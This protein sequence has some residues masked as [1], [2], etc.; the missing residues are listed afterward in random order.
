[1][2]PEA[3]YSL[4]AVTHGPGDVGATPL[5]ILPRMAKGVLEKKI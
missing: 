2:L 5:I 4:N 3:Q 1:M